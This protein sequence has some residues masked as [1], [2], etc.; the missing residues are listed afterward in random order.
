MARGT[1]LGGVLGWNTTF[2]GIAYLFTGKTKYS[3]EVRNTTARVKVKGFEKFYP[4]R[5]H[6][7]S[8]PQH[9]WRAAFREMLPFLTYRLYPPKWTAGGKTVLTLAADTFTYCLM[10]S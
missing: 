1:I 2:S 10:F 4:R 8:L 3:S 9:C 5:S 7:R 6:W